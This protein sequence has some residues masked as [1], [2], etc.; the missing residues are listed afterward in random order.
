MVFQAIRKRHNFVKLQWKHLFFP[1]H[2]EVTW[3]AQS[4]TW[5]GRELRNFKV[6]VLGPGLA[7]RCHH[8]F[9]GAWSGDNPTKIQSI[10][11]GFFPRL[12]ICGDIN[13]LYAT[14]WVSGSKDTGFPPFIAVCMQRP[15]PG[16]DFSG[17]LPL[18]VRKSKSNATK[19]WTK[20]RTCITAAQVGELLEQQRFCCKSGAE[21]SL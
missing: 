7:D 19:G 12:R 15:H 4:V 1:S 6:A 3:R 18:M 8:A 2:L 21:K 9:L 14:V 13:K 20:T 16:L 5:R 17:H 10:L 11:C